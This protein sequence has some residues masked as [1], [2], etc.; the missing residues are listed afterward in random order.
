MF[1]VYTFLPVANNKEMFIAAMI[2]VP[3]S[4]MYRV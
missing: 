1:G 3:Y 4:G 2:A